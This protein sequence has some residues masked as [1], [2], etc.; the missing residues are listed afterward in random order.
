MIRIIFISVFSLLLSSSLAQNNTKESYLNALFEEDILLVDSN[1]RALISRLNQYLIKNQYTSLSQ[2]LKEEY[3]TFQQKSLQ[4]YYSYFLSKCYIEVRNLN[5]AKALIQKETNDILI[6]YSLENFGVIYTQKGDLDIALKYFKLQQ[7]NA[8][9][10][11]TEARAL[12]NIGVTFQ[13]QY[14]LDSAIIYLQESNKIFASNNLK[15]KLINDL[16][17]AEINKSRGFHLRAKHQL[18]ILFCEAQ[19]ENLFRI[20]TQSLILLV[21]T[22]EDLYEFDSIPPYLDSA[23]R[24]D[25][26]NNKPLNLTILRY[27]MVYSP[28]EYT[29][30]K[31]QLIYYKHQLELHNNQRSAFFFRLNESLKYHDSILTNNQNL[32]PLNNFNSQK[33]QHL[34]KNWIIGLSIVFALGFLSIYI[35]NKNNINQRI[36]NLQKERQELHKRIQR[37]NRELTDLAINLKRK[38]QFDQEFLKKVEYVKNSSFSHKEQITALS[39]EL[40]NQVGQGN[41]H[42]L[43]QENINELNSRFNAILVEKHPNL[44]NYD[45]ELCGLIRLN[46]SNKEIANLKNISSQ[47]ARTAKYRLKQK[48]ELEADQDLI[49]YLQNL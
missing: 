11:L 43:L 26:T 22:Y 10:P 40:K 12:R 13:R 8:K 45:K 32:N 16:N 34:L 21:E 37:Q 49:E 2:T 25:F 39:K 6:P 47:S 24:I 41:T 48:L 14:Q 28:V 46:F 44:T 38:R 7:T 42:E 15:F 1:H 3:H 29:Q 31:E 9:S 36:K 35:Y 5:K 4:P 30:K 27:Q 19:E 33:D 23:Q 20:A 18:K 17:I